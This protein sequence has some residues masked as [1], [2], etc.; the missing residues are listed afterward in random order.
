MIRLCTPLIA[1]CATLAL[2]AT[3][4]AAAGPRDGGAGFSDDPGHDWAP[5]FD[6]LGDNEYRLIPLRRAIEIASARFDGRVIAARLTGPTPHERDRGVAL[7]HELRMLTPARDV[8]RIRIDA[9]SGDFLEV[10]GAGLT[11]AR[12]KGHDR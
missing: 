10:A 11:K 2:P 8:L 12:R 4:P 9:R 6:R 1:L 3:L 7:V 5:E